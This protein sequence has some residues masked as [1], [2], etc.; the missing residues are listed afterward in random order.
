MRPWFLLLLAVACDKGK[1]P[2]I[3]TDDA[4]G[5]DG[6]DTSTTGDD[7]GDTDGPL[8]CTSS[9]YSSNPEMSDDDVYWRTPVEL[10]FTGAA[11]EPQTTI[12]AANAAGEA[13]PLAI[14][15]DDAGL[16][17]TVQASN[18]WPGGEWVTLTVTVCTDV[19]EVN[20][21]TSNYGQPLEVSAA[22]LVGN[23][24]Y[25]D[26]G[27]ATYEKPAGLGAIIAIYLSQPLLISVFSASED[28]IE[29]IGAQGQ[30]DELTG[31]IEQDM[32]LATFGFGEAT[33]NTAPFFSATTPE[34]LIEYSGSEVPIY[35]FHIEGTFAAD[36]SAIGGGV[37][38][39]LGDTRDLGLLLGV[40]SDPGAVC[41]L[42]STFGLECSDCPD[43][44]PYCL[45]IEAYFDEGPLM[46]GVTVVEVP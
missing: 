41:E 28:R 27:E 40:G 30:T 38:K 17:A 33:F 45:D 2:S 11:A 21:G 36:G 35:D 7:T 14:L 13:I 19:T 29:L 43:G 42:A 8:P 23:T 37:A 10:T 6:D 20:F 1:D 46:P 4:D 18:Y 32:G 5:S 3:P 12:T 31:T 25:F 39:G 15:W 26:L 16:N 34:L 22:D 24:Y 9:F 44:N